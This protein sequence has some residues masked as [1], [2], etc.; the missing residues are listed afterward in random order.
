MG[1]HFLLQH[2]KTRQQ[3]SL[4]LRLL[5]QQPLR[6]P[7]LRS[8]TIALPDQLPESDRK[9]V[10]LRSELGGQLLALLNLAF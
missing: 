4:L 7:A 9:L 8:G 6:L 2:R 3:R 5:R 10:A 1:L